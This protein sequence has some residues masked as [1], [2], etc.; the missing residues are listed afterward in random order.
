MTQAFSAALHHFSPKLPLAVALSGGADSTALL[1]ACAAKWPGLVQA[2]HINHGLQ[3]AASGFEVHCQQWCA[4]LQVPLHITRIDASARSG[5]SPEDAARIARYQA[6][7][8][9]ALMDSAGPAIQSVALAQHAN[10][11]VETMLLALSRG[12]GLAGLSAMPAHWQRG[13]LQ[14]YRPLL[15]VAGADIRDWLQQR[16]ISFCED[17]TNS[18]TRYTRNRIRLQVMPALQ[19]A[20]P[21]FLDTFARS[22]GHAAQGQSL[23]DDLAGQDW[24]LVARE[25][26]LPRIKPLQQLYLGHGLA[27]QANVLRHWLKQHWQVVPSAAQLRELQA[28][29]Q[30]CTTRGHRIHIKVGPGFVQSRGPVLTWYNSQVLL[31]PI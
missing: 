1:V 2:W 17:P 24:L 15:Q 20:F 31:H 4:L 12:A 25:D 3:A 26:G 7:D 19:A 18:D 23:L 10:D 27:R 16:S 6:F 22:A 14:Y 28:Q 9:L 29:I 8:A 13:T 30:A 11:Q 5:Q 21:Q